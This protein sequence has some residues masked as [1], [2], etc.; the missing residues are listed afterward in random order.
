MS[1]KIH[2]YYRKTEPSHSLLPSTKEQLKAIGLTSDADKISTVETESCFNVQIASDLSEIQKERLEWL[3]AETFEKGNLKEESSAFDV[4]KVDG[5]FWQVEFGPRMTFTSAFSSNA[6]SICKSCDLPVGRLELS[7]RYRFVLTSAL[8]DEAVKVLKSMLHDRMTEEEYTTRLTSFD[9]GATASPVTIIPIMEQGRPALEKINEEKGLGFDDFDLDYYTKLFK[10]KLG[11]DP[12]DVECFDMGQSNSEHSRHW[13]FGGKMVIDGEEKEETLFQMVKATLPK[14]VPNNSVIAFHD[15]S[16]SIKGYECDALRPSS[17]I[18]PGP[19]KVGKQELHPILT[20]ET[21]NFPSGVAPFPGAETGTGGRL[22]DVT[23][24]G[25]GAYPVAGISA[26][27]VG[28]LNIPGYELPWEDKSFVYPGNLALP[29][30]I[31]LKASDGASDYGNKFGEP[32]IHGFTRSFGQRL[33]NGERFEWVKPI[34]FSAGVGQMDGRFSEKGAPEK[35]MLVLKIGGP[36]YRIG[37]GGGAASSRVQSSENADLDFDAVQRGDAEMENRMNR[38]MRACC[39]LG[40]KNPIV[41]VHDQGAGGNGNVLKE[42]VE[43][44]GA[45]YDIRN[46]N[47][48]DDTLSVL[49]MWGA[50]FQENNGLLIKAEDKELFISLAKRENCPISFMGTV[51]DD[52]K[53][54]VHDSKDGSTP[55]DL[56]LELVLGKMPQKT[57]VDNRTKAN[58]EPL[59]IPDGVT[60]K[61]AVDR[62]LRLLSVGSKRFL[63]HKVDR[64]VTGLCAQQQCVGPLQLPLSNV[65]VA[66]HTHFGITGTAVACGEQPIKGLINSAAMARMTVAESMTNIVWAKMSKIEDI[67]ASGNW[68]YAAKLPGEGAKMWDACVALRDCLLELGVGIDGGKDSLS[69]AARCGEEVTKAPGELTMTCYVTC[70]DITKTVTPDLKCPASGSKLLFIDLGGGKVRLGGSSLAQVFNQIGDESPDVENMSVLKK[71]MEVT[72]DLID[73]R[74]IFA[75]HDRSDGGLVVTLME[76]AFAGNCSISVDI[77][78]SASAMEVLFN[79]EAGMVIEI[80]DADVASVMEKYSAASVPIVE[81]GKVSPGDCIKISVGSAAPCIDEKMTVLRD[82]WEATSFQ[83][84]KRQRNPKCVAQEEEGLKSRKSPQWKLTY[85]PAPTDAATMESDKK[86]KVAVLRQEG[87]NGDREMI[88]AFISA[89]F[90]VWDVTVSDLLSGAATLDQFR[91]IVF[92]GGFSFADVL[93]SGKGWAGVI[94]FNNSVYQQFQAFRQRSDT[95]SLGV[96]NGCQ[97]M[98]LLGWIPSTAG[99]P[100]DKQ[101]RLLHNDSGKF[102]SRFS[103]VKIE[104][105]PAVMF[106]GMEGSSLGVWVAHGEGRFYFPDKSIHDMV[107]QDNL[108]PVRYVNDDNE[109]TEAYPFNPNGSPGG[110]AALC[111]DDGR[112]LA[113]M[114]HPER[115]FTTWQW[116]WTPSAWDGLKAGPWLQMFQNARKFCDGN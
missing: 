42:L 102:E 55:V 81:I 58:L 98:A 85:E 22:R 75:G 14:G 110:I 74:T 41:S 67:K 25:R 64:S 57:F 113:M 66:A 109:A 38:L 46:V 97:L 77:P 87:S 90:D 5:S 111:S 84:E 9:N 1:G 106:K 34:M 15:N 23:A 96:C 60:V 91:G 114:P 70:P 18:G 30:D 7:R 13:F 99:L 6:V 27:C 12:T 104:G 35:G 28:N 52:G 51:S 79:E 47:V 49:E 33:P 53:V 40:D 19:V 107:E 61:A 44:V 94:K 26:Y 76:M 63:V 101:P 62:V 56:P 17:V 59:N 108:V 45:V 100:E 71:A 80:A 103:S 105:S 82:V 112:H 95:F 24:T 16:S 68:M 83:L 29:L 54:V 39:D 69:M 50:E 2:H 8:S 37:I 4:E 86:H 116:P 3:L 11:R 92:V 72:Q 89:G 93:D 78:S 115:V 65:A 21:H 20:A 88:S 31:E 32:V 43:P 36:A 48:G 10:E 73:S